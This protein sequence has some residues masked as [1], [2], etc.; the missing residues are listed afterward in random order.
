LSKGF[1][2]YKPIRNKLRNFIR[3]ELL[4]SL[5]LTA[6][7]ASTESPEYWAKGLVPWELLLLGKWIISDWPNIN[8]NKVPTFNEFRKVINL[9]KKFL[10]KTDPWLTQE[11]GVLKFMR[12]TAF[13]QFWHQKNLSANNAG[14]AIILLIDSKLSEDLDFR[15]QQMHGLAREDIAEIT[16]LIWAHVYNGEKNFFIK[17]DYFTAIQKTMPAEKLAAY[18]KLFSMRIEDID[19]FSKSFPL[20]KNYFTEV[21]ER[22]PFLSK[23]FLFDR[24]NRI[25]LW[26]ACILTEIIEYG[27]YDLMKKINSEKFGDEFGPL[28]EKYI[29]HQLNEYNLKYTSENE[30]KKMGCKKQVDFLL[31]TTES[32]LLIEAK[33][34]EASQLTKVLPLDEIMSSSY[35][36]NIVKAIYQAHNV[37]EKLKEIGY[38]KIPYLFIVSYKE[39][40]LGDG[41]GVWN[42]FISEALKNKYD[43]DNL[44]IPIEN[45]FFISIESFD[46]FLVCT[47]GEIENVNNILKMI[48]EKKKDISSKRFIFSQYL[49]GFADKKL[50]DRRNLILGPRFD[51]FYRDVVRKHFPGQEHLLDG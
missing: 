24:Q 8:G 10:D 34:I 17:T 37:Y 41:S 25:L 7:K 19:S 20:P 33:A 51:K 21:F 31:E 12:R 38:Q 14:R 11:G 26:S 28:F 27:V 5:A 1:E 30:L 50:D 3:E 2:E 18:F 22:T 39:L 29:T 47:N 16:L 9:V 45:I 49:E 44:N 48:L 36:D 32:I 6:C 42:E 15:F 35:S 13:Q 46:N 23:P 43:I 40:Y 4:V